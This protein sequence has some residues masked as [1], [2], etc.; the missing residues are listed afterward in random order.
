MADSTPLVVE[1][2]GDALLIGFNRPEKRNAIDLAMTEAV[3]QVLTEH[4]RE[5]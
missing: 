4:A 1:R 2:R 5:R 3:H